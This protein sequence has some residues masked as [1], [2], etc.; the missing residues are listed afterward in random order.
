MSYLKNKINRSNAH[1]FLGLGFI[2]RRLRLIGRLGG[3]GI[4]ALVMCFHEP[5]PYITL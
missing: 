5:L 2:G 4:V 3:S 1:R